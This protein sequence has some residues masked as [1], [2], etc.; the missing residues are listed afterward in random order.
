[1]ASGFRASA[2]DQAQAALSEVEG[3]V[4]RQDRVMRTLCVRRRTAIHL[5]WMM[6]CPSVGDS[7]MFCSRY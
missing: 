4:C 1:M 7:Q 6:L 5:C 3:A 2:F